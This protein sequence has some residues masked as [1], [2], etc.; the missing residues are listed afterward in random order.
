MHSTRHCQGPGVED[1]GH[2]FGEGKPH[3]GT[4]FHS[5]RLAVTMQPST[6]RVLHDH[7]AKEF[8]SDREIRAQDLEGNR[9]FAR[10]KG[11]YGRWTR[12]WVSSCGLR[13][14][15]KMDRSTVRPQLAASALDMRILPLGAPPT[16]VVERQQPL[17]TPRHASTRACRYID[18]LRERSFAASG[19]MFSTRAVQFA[20]L[21]RVIFLSR[22][23]GS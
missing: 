8:S 22:G 21:M 13:T 10:Y 7:L 3:V 6:T 15:L 4:A 19:K 5:V 18:L 23:E 12:L 16:P 17:T 2:T 14:T 20:M 9:A 11:A 1:Q